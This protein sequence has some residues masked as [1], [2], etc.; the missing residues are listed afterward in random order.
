MH[1]APVGNPILAGLEPLFL[2]QCSYVRQEL[3]VYPEVVNWVAHKGEGTPASNFFAEPPLVKGLL[4]AMR[5]GPI[6]VPVY[7]VVR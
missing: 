5:A 4:D 1:W 2:Q 7:K 6:Q 3:S